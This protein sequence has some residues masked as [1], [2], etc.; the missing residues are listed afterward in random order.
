M[1]FNQFDPYYDTARIVGLQ[2]SRENI[3]EKW[4]WDEYP[5]S[6][7]TRLMRGTSRHEDKQI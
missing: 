2:Y 1:I 5:L 4:S 3:M 7:N 6:I